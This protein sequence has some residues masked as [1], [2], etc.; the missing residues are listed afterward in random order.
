MKIKPNNS[1]HNACILRDVYHTEDDAPYMLN[2]QC[3]PNPKFY[4]KMQWDELGNIVKVFGR[5]VIDEP[6]IYFLQK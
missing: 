3:A 2:E 5:K 6:Y 1:F 4:D